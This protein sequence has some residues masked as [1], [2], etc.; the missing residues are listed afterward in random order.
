MLV[1]SNRAHANEQ[2][3]GAVVTYEYS[4]ATRRSLLPKLGDPRELARLG[5]AETSEPHQGLLVGTQ[6]TQR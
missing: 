1:R 5:H 3:R 4:N 6:R 2:S